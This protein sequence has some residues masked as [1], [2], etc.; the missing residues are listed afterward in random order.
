V[1]DLGHFVRLVYNS[2]VL[3][4]A[5][6]AW[7]VSRRH[8]LGL[9]AAAAAAVAVGPVQAAAPQFQVALLGSGGSVI[10]QAVDEL[11]RI[12]Q[13]CVVDRASWDSIPP[14]ASGD[15]LPAGDV[16]IRP[17]DFYPDMFSRD[18]Y[19]VLAA[20]GSK[21]LLDATQAKFHADQANTL[22]GHVATALRRDGSVSPSCYQDD[23]STIMDVLREYERVRLGA[24]PEAR[25]LAASYGF[26]QAHVQDGLY[27]TVGDPST[28]AGH[29]WADTL[30]MPNP[31]AISYNQGLYCAALAAL[32]HMGV[33]VPVDQPPLAQ[34][35]Y[36]QLV[37]SADG[38]TLAQRQGSTA[39]DVS[40]LAGDAL[41][42]YY[43]GQPLLPNGIV[44]ATLK[45]LLDRSAAHQS[46]QFIGFRGLTA[47]D[48]SFLSRANF[49]S[50]ESVP[51]NYQNGGSWFLYDALAL[52]S[53][54]A[55]GSAQAAD[56][57]RQRIVS[58]YSRA[59]TFHEFTRTSPTIVDVR[60][61]YG[62]NSFVARLVA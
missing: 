1:A 27:V 17:S 18:S 16:W 32:A 13:L 33:A 53:A 11:R 25:S 9:A 12:A 43:F 36:A 47:F 8:F 34:T 14:P 42:I 50:P 35:R 10:Q 20:L 38:A 22:D 61:D 45:R 24:M 48:G 7:S 28:G 2:S 3:P 39:V 56:L 59:Q 15:Y 19:W 55:R 26:I 40:A 23:E 5:G 30:R 57:L 49:T 21:A 4:A 51:G 60:H 58:E 29:Y 52:Y 44:L 54:A 6:L 31:Q 46:G 62:W 37:S 41:S